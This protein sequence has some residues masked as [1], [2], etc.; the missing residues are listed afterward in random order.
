LSRWLYIIAVSVAWLSACAA[1]GGGVNG[2]KTGTP[3]A[4]GDAPA[5]P[6]TRASACTGGIF[7]PARGAKADSRNDPTLI[8][9]RAVTVDFSKLDPPPARLV[10]NLFGD[11]CLVAIRD[12]ADAPGGVWTGTIEGS[13]DG[14]VSLVMKSDTLIGSVV[15]PPRYFQIRL[16]RDAVHVIRQVD[17]SKS[18]REGL[19]SA[20]PSVGPRPPS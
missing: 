19:P 16:L 2:T 14:D 8:R 7:A 3:A 5:P 15:S 9:E 4:S 10:L 12:K 1:S 18:R 20:P 11:V 17:P 6:D 13:K